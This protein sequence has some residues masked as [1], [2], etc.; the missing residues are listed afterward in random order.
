V[1]RSFVS[2]FPD[3]HPLFTQV[4]L[5]TFTRFVEARYPTQDDDPDQT[6]FSELISLLKAGERS[7]NGLRFDVVGWS[8]TGLCRAT[9]ED[10]FAAFHA[11]GFEE[12]RWGD[13]SLIILADGMGGCNAGEVASA[14]A[15]SSIR[16]TLF[17]K[18]PW[19]M[20]HS[21]DPSKTPEFKED[22]ILHSMHEAVQLANS[23]IH[24][25][26][27]QGDGTQIG[28]GCTCE[29][30]FLLRGQLFMSHVGD[31]RTYLYRAGQIRQLSQDQTLVNRM[32]ATGVITVE[33]AENH[34]RRH[35]LD[36]ALGSS[37]AVEVQLLTEKLQVGDVLVFCSDGLTTHVNDRG[38]CEVLRNVSSAEAAARRL[39]N[40]A[41]ALG[42][43]DNVTV[44]VVRVS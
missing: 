44:V 27:E 42:G 19:T 5:K 34:P 41:N 7:A 21:K 30:G 25:A 16:Q 36:Q 15:I 28:M 29:V 6:G 18:P 23:T 38:I 1:P 10:A 9:N 8:S 3:G 39:V 4:V 2:I 14:L 11:S 43:S 26:A 31:S 17:E 35:E 12:D 40:L 33:E 20:F 22:D 32:V 37:H 13:Q 24:A